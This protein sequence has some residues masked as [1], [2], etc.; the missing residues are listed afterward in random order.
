MKRM[1]GIFQVVVVVVAV[2]VVVSCV[3]VRIT[4]I[5]SSSEFLVSGIL[6]KQPVV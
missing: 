2:V 3:T 5:L 4:K 1:V 6:E